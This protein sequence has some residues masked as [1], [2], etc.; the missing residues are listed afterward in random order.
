MGQSDFV[1]GTPIRFNV[2]L[3][4]AFGNV[5]TIDTL[6]DL[7]VKFKR[8]SSGEV[9]TGRGLLSSYIFFSLS[10]FV[11][12]TQ[13]LL[14][15][16]VLTLSPTVHD[17]EPLATGAVTRVFEGQAPGMG[18]MVGE[19]R[20]NREI[21]LDSM[22]LNRPISV[23]CFPR[24]ALMLCLQLRKGIQPAVRFAARSV[25]AL[26]AILYDHYT[27]AIYRNRPIDTEI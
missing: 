14:P 15:Q 18:Y 17:S 5:A 10:R 22:L 24:R 4:D 8:Q 7:L 3:R 12:E 13:Q 25:D 27:Q 9:A 1:A 19:C 16:N 11:T 23:Y 26:P 21:R 2:D 6:S 20:L